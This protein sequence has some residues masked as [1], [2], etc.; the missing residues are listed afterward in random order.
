MDHVEMEKT[1][2]DGD[3]EYRFRLIHDETPNSPREWDNLGTIVAWHSRYDLGDESG[4]EDPSQWYRDWKTE[5]PDGMIF[6]LFMYDHG[7]IA[8]S[9]RSFMGRA[10][11]AE[12]DSGQ[13]GWVYVTRAK[14]VDEQMGDWS[15]D[16]VRE[17]VEAEIDTYSKYINGDV[18]GFTLESRPTAP[19]PSCNRSHDWELEDS[20]WGFFGS[21]IEKNG[22][23]DHLGATTRA[24][25]VA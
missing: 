10:H 6:P 21:D 7:G 4:G 8:L 18:W 24:A 2:T 19:C 3:T 12:W 20:C 11:H 22:V 25:L 16:R 17:G 13:V 1:W 14:L 5:N 23:L 9:V 15:E